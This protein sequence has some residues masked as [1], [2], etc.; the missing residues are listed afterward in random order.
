MSPCR[1]QTVSA[2]SAVTSTALAEDGDA[3]NVDKPGPVQVTYA[4]SHVQKITTYGGFTLVEWQEYLSIGVL[5]VD[6][7]HKLLFEKFNAFLAAC[8]SGTEAD[9][10]Y[11]LFWFVEAYT[12]THFRE[13][14]SLMQRVG[15]PEFLKH[16]ERHVAFTD[17]IGKL[18]ERL[19]SEGPTQSLVSAITTFISGWLVEH[20]SKHDRAIGR[21]MTTAGMPEAT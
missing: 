14:E 20:I 3:I 8:H 19:K 2:S 7:Q 13:E 11:R 10:T 12:V 18:K 16:R 1:S 15:F 21:Y 5:E 6:I 9:G 4:R 17:E